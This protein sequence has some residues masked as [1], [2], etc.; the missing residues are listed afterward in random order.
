M[1]TTAKLDSKMSRAAQDGLEGWVLPLYA[2]PGKRIVGVIELAHVERTQPAP[3]AD[4]EP[5]VKLRITH[6]EIAN[7]EQENILR[8]AMK[9][10]HL[11]R[12]AYGTLDEDGELQ[13]SQGTLER[14]GGMLHAVEAARLRAA[15]VHWREQALRVYSI[16]EATVTEMRHEIDMLARG[17]AAVLQVSDDDSDEA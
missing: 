17:L 3:D 4:K 2:T 15:V 5:S 10:L 7:D 13:L 9:A 12:T 11:H 1:T 14:T 6:L 16:P 8:E